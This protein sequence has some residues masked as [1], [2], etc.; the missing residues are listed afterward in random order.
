TRDG[1]T[2]N[3]GRYN[4][5]N[6]AYSAVYTS[7]DM[8]DEIRITANN[9][10]AALGRGSAQVQMLTRSGG[11]AF[12]GALFYTNN[13]SKFTTQPYF[14]NLNGS[15]RS[16]TNRNQFGGRLGGPIKKNKAFFFVLID[17]QRY[18]E[19]TNFVA[20]VLTEP[21]RQG[22]FRFLTQGATGANAGVSRRN[23]NAFST[24]PS[25]NLQGQI[26]KA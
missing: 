2:T 14:A 15:E 26:Y 25:V 1:L 23:G 5:S 20:T 18:L 19:K 8:V 24:T 7:P 22:I 11:N 6:G 9:I 3:D 12:H 21:A 4:A 17:D 16:Y 10:D 13:N